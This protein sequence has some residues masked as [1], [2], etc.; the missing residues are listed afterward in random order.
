MNTQE[1]AKV[2]P[3]I[4]RGDA[5]GNCAVGAALLSASMLGSVLLFALKNLT[6]G[7]AAAL[8]LVAIVSL[9]TLVFG[10]IRLSRQAVLLAHIA[11]LGVGPEQVEIWLT[12][13][14]SDLPLARR[15]A[16]GE[17]FSLV[18]AQT[19]TATSPATATDTGQA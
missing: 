3:N 11:R 7:V 5:V 10:S 15:Q 8:M 2:G 1:L 12:N 17:I 13:L 18:S 9:C 19:S 14:R 4:F 16:L 6:G